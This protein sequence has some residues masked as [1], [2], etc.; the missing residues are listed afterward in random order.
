MSKKSNIERI[1]KHLICADVFYLHD[2]D[3]PDEDL[4]RCPMPEHDDHNPSF[5][6]YYDQNDVSKFKCHSQCDIQGDIIDLEMALSGSD[7]RDAIDRLTKVAVHQRMNASC[8]K[9]MMKSSQ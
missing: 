6:L 4:I 7:K 1:K 5:S 9:P 8:S 3:V 2:I